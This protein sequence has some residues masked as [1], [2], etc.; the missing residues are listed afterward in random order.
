[1]SP[2]GTS[3][4]QSLI[5]SIFAVF[6][7]PRTRYLMDKIAF[8]K[9]FEQPQT[10]DDLKSLLPEKYQHALEMVRLGPSAR[11]QQPWRIVITNG[12][13]RMHLFDESRMSYYSRLDM[14]IAMC[15]LELALASSQ[16]DPCLPIDSY[17]NVAGKW[18][19]YDGDEVM[20]ECK[21]DVRCSGWFSLPLKY[22][23]TWEPNQ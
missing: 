8:F 11:N 15:H 10:A 22:V 23:A 6:E 7:M 21:G 3:Q 5:G 13:G 18:V 12:S 14:G 1:M 4:A 20:K 9:T 19:V 17:T 16:T 2:L